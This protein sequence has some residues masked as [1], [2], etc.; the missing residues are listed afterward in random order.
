[1]KRFFALVAAASF[2]LVPFAS[3]AATAAPVDPVNS[4]MS[5][6][7]T[8]LSANG[9]DNARI[10]VTVR[11]TNLAEMSG[12]T[13]TLTSSRGSQDEIRVESGT[14]D[15]LGAAYFRIFSLKDGAATFTAM[16]N[17]VTLQRTVTVTYSG[18]LS[19][20]LHDG[21]LIKIPDDN[22]AST[23]SDTAVY[24]Y[25]ADGRRY[26]FPNEKVYYTWYPDFSKVQV[27][28]IDQMGLIPI[29]GNVTYKAGSKLV[30]F[31]TDT[32]TYLPTKHGV[33][34]WVQSEDVAKGLFGDDWN[35]KVDDISEAFYVNYTFGNPIASSLDAPLDVIT[36]GDGTI[37]ADKG[38]GQ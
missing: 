7:N 16:V 29:A 3:H 13:V 30:K 26:V 18:G 37:D 20:P 34:R 5:V 24:Y 2:A 27:L 11:D 31:Q 8:A 10:T 15:S 14:T 1:M 12:Q 4:R 33:L 32:K 9:I 6:D 25:G 38:L 28:P 36:T 35:T 21:D 22:D 19:F 23:L 17:G